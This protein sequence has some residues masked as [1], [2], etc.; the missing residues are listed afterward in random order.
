MTLRGYIDEDVWLEETMSRWISVQQKDG[1]R[2]NVVSV[3]GSRE[4]M[5]NSNGMDGGVKMKW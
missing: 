5:W 3:D 2:D 4:R 1:S